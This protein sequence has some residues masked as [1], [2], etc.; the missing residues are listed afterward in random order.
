MEEQRRE[1]LDVEGLRAHYARTSRQWAERHCGPRRSR[2]CVSVGTRTYRTWLLY[3][4]AASVAFE[5]GWI[6]LSQV[7]GARSDPAARVAPA[8]REGLYAPSAVDGAGAPGRCA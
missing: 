6:G 8:T 4:T 2:R 5:Q 1:V 7:L 3:L